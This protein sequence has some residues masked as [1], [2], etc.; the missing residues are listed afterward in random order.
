MVDM[1]IRDEE[2]S[3]YALQ[4]SSLGASIEG[5]INDLKTQLEYV[6]NEGATSGSF[7]DNLLL[8]IEVI[9]SIS[10]KLEEQTTAI[11]ASVESYLY[12]IDGLDGQFY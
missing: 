1:K 10:G 2:L 4:L 9:S 11:K 12:N 7:H 6:C 8:F 3:S 5:R